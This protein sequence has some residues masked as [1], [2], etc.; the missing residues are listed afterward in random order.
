MRY[1]DGM[2]LN[3]LSSTSRRKDARADS[4][5][6]CGYRTVHIKG[7]NYY[8][9]RIIWLISHGSDPAGFIDHIDGNSLNNHID[10]LRVAPHEMNMCNRSAPRHSTSGMK[11]LHRRKD[12]GKWRVYLSVHN[13]RI[14]LG[15]F[16]DKAEAINVL[17]SARK[18][19]HGEYAKD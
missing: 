4:S 6:C 8:A 10:N 16:A 19:M 12:S 11:G 3:N 7:R 1:E 13:K 18:H 5:I 9:H 2:L 17:K 15:T 14:N